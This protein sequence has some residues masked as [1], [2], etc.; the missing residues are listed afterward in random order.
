MKKVLKFKVKN[1]K[2][3]Q[4][5]INEKSFP[6]KLTHPL[7]YAKTMKSKNGEKQTQSMKAKLKA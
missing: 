5:F 4:E 2:V 1:D 7:P 3:F 6:T